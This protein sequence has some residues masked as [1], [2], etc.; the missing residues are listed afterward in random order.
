[1][2][3][4]QVIAVALVAFLLL[5]PSCASY[6]KR[7]IKFQELVVNGKFQEASNWIVNDKKSQKNRHRLLFL[8]NKGFV[9][10]MLGNYAEA[11]KF[12]IEADQLMENTRASLGEQALALI[13]TPTVKPY[14]PED[15]ERVLVHFY[16]ALGFMQ[17]GNM[18]S[19]LVEARRINLELGDLN[20]KYKSK[21]NR[22][23]SDAFAHLL[24]GLAYER[25]R[26][27]NNAFIAYRNAL[28]TIENIYS[29]VFGVS[30][31]EQLKHDIIRMAKLTGFN[32]E[33]EYY[34]KKF[35]F[36]QTIEAFDASAVV[37]WS[38]GFGP[39]K[40]QRTIEFYLVPLGSNNYQ[41]LNNLLG[42][43]LT[44]NFGD[45][46]KDQRAAL[47]AMKV[48]R[49]AFPRYLQRIPLFNQ[50]S[51]QVNNQKRE[52]QLIE[53]IDL[54]AEKTLEDRMLR[55]SGQALARLVAKKT[56]EIAVRSQNKTAG[57]LTSL[58]GAI[59]EQADTRN[60]QTLPAKVY[61]ARIPL[62]EGYN[63]IEFNARST[64]GNKTESA[65]FEINQAIKGNLYFINQHS[66]STSP[67]VFT[68]N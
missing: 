5:F 4:K 27:Y 52:F 43:N 54:I 12:F 10:F 9:T 62:Q 18:E 36:D 64:N 61:Y 38:S 2:R 49:L 48:I 45:L 66:L 22:Y 29:P 11:N 58:A 24:I 1:M 13:S 3:C 26:D 39:V 41:F 8:L 46:N 47:D 40:D 35:G 21:K 34:Q 28:E 55:E 57:D 67:P 51:I 15:H 25:D 31:P 32:D 44:L 17:L 20:S 42:I 19:A 53:P 14:V 6:Y 68:R 23:S 50:A 60:W 59:S 7:N 16:T 33:V 56:L 30:V 63:C 65:K 37:F